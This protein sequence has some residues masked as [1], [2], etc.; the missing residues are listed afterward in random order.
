MLDR[1]LPGRID[2]SYRGHPLALWL[3]GA[4]V[5]VK[6]LQGV[7]VIFNGSEIARS[8]D[9]IPLDS[10]PPAAAQTVVALFA[11]TGFSRLVVSALCVLALV[12]YR[13][14]VPF[15]LGLLAVD[16]L[17]KELLLH[18]IPVPTVGPVPGPFVNLGLLLALL[19]RADRS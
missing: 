16:Y 1:L 4:A 7:M 6:I 18:F 8:A 13:A 17:L 12:R 3:F 15:M 19:T 9:R 2:S 10:F 5:A 11:L 14:A